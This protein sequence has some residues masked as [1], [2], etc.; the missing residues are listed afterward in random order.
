MDAPVAVSRLPVG[1]SAMTRAGRPARARAMAV[2]CCSPPDSWL[3]RCP[4]PVAEPDPLDGRLGQPAALGDPAA[5]VEQAVGDV[6]EH[7]EAVEQEELLEDEAQSPGPQARQLLVGHGR[8][9][10]AGDADHA[11]GGPLQGAH[12]VQ[13]GALARPRRADDG[14]QL[15]LVDPQADAGQGHDRWVAGVLLDHV[16]QLQDRRRRGRPRRTADRDG[17]RSRRG[18]LDPRAGA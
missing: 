4:M 8:G 7:A 9:V 15:A 11:A 16:D 10:L 1:S 2:R 3:G 5:A 18:H 14:D 17:R 12:D 6:V 13:Q